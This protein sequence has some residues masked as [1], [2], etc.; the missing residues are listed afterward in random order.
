[1]G[2]LSLVTVTIELEQIPTSAFARARREVARADTLTPLHADLKAV[3]T[4][5]LHQQGYS[6]VTYEPY[7]PHGM[8]RADVASVPA[9]YYVEVGHVAD[10]SRV[11]H[12]LG[13]DVVMRGN[14]ISSVLKRYPSD[15]DPTAEIQ[16]IVSVPYPVDDPTAR[17]WN[18]DELD[19]HT[20]SRGRRQA[21]TPNRRHQWWCE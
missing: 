20:F 12:M 9:D 10:P 6:E 19:V 17:E 18:R 3:A 11:Y 14:R 15:T 4:W 21:S 8:R 5:F 7:Y 2:Y 13:I 16:G 1:M